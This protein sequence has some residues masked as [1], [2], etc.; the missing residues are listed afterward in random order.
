MG[1]PEYGLP[2]K[3]NTRL[4][5]MPSSSSTIISSPKSATTH[6]IP[7]LRKG[8]VK[9][10]VR[11]Y[12][13]PYT[14]TGGEVLN[15]RV[16]KQGKTMAK[17]TYSPAPLGG[18]TTVELLFPDGGSYEGVALCSRKDRFDRRAGIALALSR[19][20]TARK[21]H[22]ANAAGWAPTHE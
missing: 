19:A 22:M 4:K 7:T 12:R 3:Q 6:V 5:P 1:R 14:S 21:T 15:P 10:R 2:L 16:R 17:S 13:Y 18:K 11:N 20:L 8:G 9:V